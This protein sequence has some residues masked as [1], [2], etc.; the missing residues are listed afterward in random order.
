[1]KPLRRK[2]ANADYLKRAR[3]DASKTRRK[4]KDYKK[5]HLERK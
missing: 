3:S 1:V 5:A 2:Y 4:D